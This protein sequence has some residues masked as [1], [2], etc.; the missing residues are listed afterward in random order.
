MRALIAVGSFL[1]KQPLLAHLR[2]RG[3][4]VDCVHTS[5]DT[6]DFV[7]HNEF[8][9]VI[10]DLSL[11]YICDTDLVRH[12][13]SLDKNLSIL[14]VSPTPYA[15]SIVATLAA[16]ADSAIALPFD[17]AE[18]EARMQAL[19]RRSRGHSQQTLSA[20]AITVN[21][22]THQVT[23]NGCPI[24]L[25]IKEAAVLKLLLLRRNHLVTKATFL[26]QLYVNAEGEPDPKI[27]DVFVCRVRKKLAAAGVLNV[28]GTV[29]G[30]GYVVREAH[31]ERKP[32][33]RPLDVDR[34]G[35]AALTHFR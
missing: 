33:R 26:S 25:T 27:V 16:G 10:I 23:V 1:A 17:M 20:G 3:H 19:V 4:Q 35:V 11:S 13:R 9:I 14:A 30:K 5:H 29:R 2:S 31:C 21:L 28:I 8:D 22:D 12:L 6:L 15:V 32:N 7:Q 18:L 24:H 34:R